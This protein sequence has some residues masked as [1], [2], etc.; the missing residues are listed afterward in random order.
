MLKNLL[1]V[2]YTAVYADM[3]QDPIVLGTTQ[4]ENEK[5][6]TVPLVYAWKCK[7]PDQWTIPFLHYITGHIPG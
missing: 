2:I 5:A 7:K 4:T 1:R 6:V 3:A